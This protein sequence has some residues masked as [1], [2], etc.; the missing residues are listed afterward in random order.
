MRR[1][2]LRVI[3][4][5]TRNSL[6]TDEHLAMGIAWHS[7]HTRKDDCFI[8]SV[9]KS[10]TTSCIIVECLCGYRR[11]VHCRELREAKAAVPANVDAPILLNEHML[12]DLSPLDREVVTLFWFRHKPKTR[13]CSIWLIERMPTSGAVRIGCTC[14]YTDEILDMSAAVESRVGK[15]QICEEQECDD[16]E[17]VLRRELRRLRVALDG[18]RRRSRMLSNRVQGDR[19]RFHD[20]EVKLGYLRRQASCRHAEM[21]PSHRVEHRYFDKCVECGFVETSS[22]TIEEEGLLTG[23]AKLP[24]YH[25]KKSKV[26]IRGD[27][28]EDHE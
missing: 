7:H 1:L 22:P 19:N 4:E 11:S 18:E 21:T 9:R 6:S 2:Q 13:I 5:L 10:V 24:D 25:P 20:M 3:S 8:S 23:V 17:D 27:W 14:G 16:D 26:A 28:L 15:I 12:R